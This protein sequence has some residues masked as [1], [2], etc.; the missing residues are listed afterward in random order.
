VLLYSTSSALWWGSFDWFLDHLTRTFPPSA[1][2]KEPGLMDVWLSPPVAALYHNHSWT[3]QHIAAASSS[4]LSVILTQ[5]LDVCR[6]RL[7]VSS[8]AGDGLTARSVMKA[9]WREGG[10]KSLMTGLGPR[11][12]SVVPSSVLT[13][14]VYQQAKLF[15]V[16][17]KQRR[18]KANMQL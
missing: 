14:A 18:I 3:A 16:E 5:P 13:M 17:S 2:P 7:M 8:R 9:L 15:S 11:I 6:T 4:L 12:T 1:P 10:V